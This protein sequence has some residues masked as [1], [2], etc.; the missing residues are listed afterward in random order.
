MDSILLLEARGRPS[1][2]LCSG[3]DICKLDVLFSCEF[4]TS[5]TTHLL[6][7][8][9]LL[10]TEVKVQFVREKFVEKD[11]KCDDNPKVRCIVNDYPR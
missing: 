9:Q 3:I 6:I 11:S 5:T 7:T 10:S 1:F 4:S 8:L 2:Y